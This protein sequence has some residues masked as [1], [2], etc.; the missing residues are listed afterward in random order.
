[1][2]PYQKRRS[3]RPIPLLADHGQ[4]RYLNLCGTCYHYPSTAF[5]VCMTT[6]VPFK[7]FHVSHHS[8]AAREADLIPLPNKY[9]FMIRGWGCY[10]VANG[11]ICRT[12]S[13]LRAILRDGHGS[14]I[15]EVREVPY[16]QRHNELKRNNATHKFDAYHAGTRIGLVAFEDVEPTEPMET[17]LKIYRT[18]DQAQLVVRSTKLGQF[19]VSFAFCVGNNLS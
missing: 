15:L 11:A 8:F 9:T 18:D 14:N 1:M 2:P 13:N 6:I 4:E 16:I 3:E 12:T 7:W 17:C 5:E 19:F 10:A